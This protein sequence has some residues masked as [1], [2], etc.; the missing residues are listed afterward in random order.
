MAG[1]HISFSFSFR[2]SGHLEFS[3]AFGSMPSG[4][5]V[6]NNN[7]NSTNCQKA[8]KNPG[9]TGAGAAAAL[10]VNYK[11]NHKTEVTACTAQSTDL[12]LLRD[13]KH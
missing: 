13:Q 10:G 4:I 2:N 9:Q 5:V 3:R 11:L 1:K 7:I 8:E 6:K 12:D